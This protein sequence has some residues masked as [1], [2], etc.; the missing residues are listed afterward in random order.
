MAVSLVASPWTQD[1][2][3]TTLPEVGLVAGVA[4]WYARRNAAWGALCVVVHDQAAQLGP[5]AESYSQAEDDAELAA[6]LRRPSPLDTSRRAQEQRRRSLTASA[7]RR[8]VAFLVGQRLAPRV[9]ADAAPLFLPSGPGAVL[10][11]DDFSEAVGTP[12]N[13]KA[14]DVGGPWADTAGAFQ[15]VAAGGAGM[16]AG[17]VFVTSCAPSIPAGGAY[18]QG[19][20]TAGGGTL[21]GDSPG[22][23]LYTTEGG[24]YAGYTLEGRGT[25]SVSTRLLRNGVSLGIGANLPSGVGDV[26]RLEE[27]GSGNLEAFVNGA[28]WIGPVNDTAFTSGPAGIKGQNNSATVV[29]IDDFEAGSLVVPP[30]TAARYRARLCACANG[31]VPRGGIAWGPA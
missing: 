22:V 15:V 10:A 11:A 18:V 3:G 8:R 17:T 19:E 27:D 7:R 13:G 2:D 26:L 24:A 6:A 28:P 5:L 12:L 29:A 1:D 4:T 14:A 31:L 16:S 25:A 20:E 9:P 30:A 21:F 23:A